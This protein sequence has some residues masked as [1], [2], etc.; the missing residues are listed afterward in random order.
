M[1]TTCLTE[2]SLDSETSPAVD[3]VDAF[4]MDL[5]AEAPE[6]DAS[7]QGSEKPSE[8]PAPSEE[9]AAEPADTPAETEEE[10]PAAPPELGDDAKFT[11]KVGDEIRELT[12]AELR[13]LVS[14]EAEIAQVH[15]AAQAQRD[16]WQQ[17]VQRVQTALTGQVERARE[18]LQGYEG[19]DWFDLA[20]NLPKEDMD[21]LR[22]A[23]EADASNLKFLE[24]EL[25]SHV[26][27]THEAARAATLEEAKQAHV[28][29]MGP[30]ERGGIPGW[31]QP[32]YS[33]IVEHAVREGL[34][35]E[36]AQS[37]VHPA[38]IRL[39]HDA[40]QFRRAKAAAAAKADKAREDAK[41]A[42]R[43]PRAPAAAERDVKTDPA[44]EA[45]HRLKRSG[46]IDD[47]AAVF[48]ADLTAA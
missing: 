41:P 45:K 18:R 30:V 20:R 42:A 37:V 14:R 15:Q 47:A 16:A 7:P 28:V 27:K 40:M 29:L 19:L 8:D 43:T 6:E 9:T 48:L 5:L 13:A 38:A 24:Q 12:G 4:L 2:I 32:L 17:D 31:S 35:R 22:K 26:A 10:A 21:A 33:E 1:K 39:M 3:P 46:S 11:L 23:Y 25:D 36:F 34:P 44:V